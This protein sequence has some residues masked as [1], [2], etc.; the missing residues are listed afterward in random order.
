MLNT[1]TP[2]QNLTKPKVF[3]NIC[4]KLLA[5]P[6]VLFSETAAMFFDRTKIPTSILCMVPQGTFIPSLSLIGQVV[7]EEKIFERKNRKKTS[8]KGNNSNMA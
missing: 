4:E 7:S 1:F 8:K 2:C 5:H 3:G 6:Y